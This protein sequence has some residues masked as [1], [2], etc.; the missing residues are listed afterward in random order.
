[1]VGERRDHL[2]VD[3]ADG[4]AGRDVAQRVEAG[5]VPSLR[6]PPSTKTESHLA[7]QAAGPTAA[8]EFHREHH[9][10]AV[11]GDGGA[12]DVVLRAHRAGG[13]EG[14]LLGV[15]GREDHPAPVGPASPRGPRPPRPGSPPRPRCRRRRGRRRGCWRRGD[16]SARRRAPAVDVAAHGGDHVMP[17][18][19]RGL[20]GGVEGRGRGGR[21]RR[22][23]GRAPP[24][25][26][27]VRR[28]RRRVGAE[29]FHEGAGGGAAVM[30]AGDRT[31]GA[32]GASRAQPGGAP[33]AARRGGRPH[34]APT[35][36]PGSR[37]SVTSSRAHPAEPQSTSRTAS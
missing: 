20:L 14:R 23:G 7:G 9:V 19:R 32:S 26:V 12:A 31:T 5:E 6:S 27:P 29:G 11:E 35:D 33:A 34:M 10:D 22:G 17:S 28:P 15:E 13:V 30:A 1:M 8:E 18:Q 36:R 24:P 3:A 4:D 37:A 2:G 21:R 25:G 16:R